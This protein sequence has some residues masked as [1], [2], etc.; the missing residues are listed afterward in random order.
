[1]FV[2][3]N[4]AAVPG[5]APWIEAVVEDCAADDPDVATGCQATGLDK[6]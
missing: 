4:S 6:T 3:A 1:M 2:G 5:S